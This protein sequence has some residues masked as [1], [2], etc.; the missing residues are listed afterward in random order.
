MVRKRSGVAVRLVVESALS[1]PRYARAAV[2]RRLLP[3]REP[4]LAAELHRREQ[5]IPAA[6]RDGFHCG[7]GAPRNTGRASDGGVHGASLASLFQSRDSKP[8]ATLRAL[9]NAARQVH[10]DCRCGL[11]GQSTIW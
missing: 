10:C 3:N 11:L 1:P 9:A 5:V 4:A 8:L 2:F 6:G 7:A